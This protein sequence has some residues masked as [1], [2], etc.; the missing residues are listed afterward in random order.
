MAALHRYPWLVSSL[1]VFGLIVSGCDGSKTQEEIAARDAIS[2]QS[3]T[4]ESAPASAVASGHEHEQDADAEMILLP[5]LEAV[6]LKGELLRVVAS[7]SIIGD[8][9]AQVGGEAIAL[10][11]LMGP[12]EDPHSYKPGAQDLTAVAD[13]HVIFVNGWDLE[14]GLA[15]DLEVIGEDV[16]IVAISA[17]VEPLTFGEGAPAHHRSADPHVW[18]SI[19][20][21]VQ[22]VENAERVLGDLDPANADTYARNTEAYLVEL[23]AL[24]EYIRSQVER[25]PEGSRLLVTNHEAFGYFAHEYGFA[26]LGTVIPGASTLAEPSA[27]ELAG[28]IEELK[29]HDVCTIFAETSAS[30]KLA[31]TVAGE[32]DECSSVRVLELFTGAIGPHGSNADSYLGMLRANVDAIVNGLL[33][34]T[35]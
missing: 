16:P 27:R 12:G 30:D 24:D 31:R 33:W 9:V 18:F 14:E 1:L 22:W 23:K 7:T 3:E 13:A 28:L 32:L 4:D 6:E 21:V 8:V 11:I 29:E 17:Y 25:I 19:P 15:H 10:T 5:E 26:V 34:H 35:N 2:A 20:N